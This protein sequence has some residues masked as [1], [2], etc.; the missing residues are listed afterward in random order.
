M[1]NFAL[2]ILCMLVH[3]HT[4]THTQRHMI[5]NHE[6]D[7][8]AIDD[9]KSTLVHKA[10]MHGHIGVLSMLVKEAGLPPNTLQLPDENFST[11]ALLAIQVGVATTSECGHVK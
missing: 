9:H 7:A 4:H 8:L 10:A 1:Q 6:T 5:T 2:I 3:T 11:P